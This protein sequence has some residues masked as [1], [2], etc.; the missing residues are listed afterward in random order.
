MNM[1]NRYDHLATRLLETVGGATGAVPPRTREAVRRRAVDLVAGQ[2]PS[3]ATRADLPDDLAR[4]VDA[5]IRHAY[6][7]TDEDVGRLTRAGHSDDEVFE[8]TVT[9]AV[10]A[11]TARL[12]RVLELLRGGR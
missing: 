5:V 6:R 10:G 11:G 2:D 9:A 1:P 4:H 8:V 7:V 3:R 12:N